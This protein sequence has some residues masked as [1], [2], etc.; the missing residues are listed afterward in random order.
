MKTK[1]KQKQQRKTKQQKQQQRISA[2][3]LVAAFCASLI[4]CGKSDVSVSGSAA[5]I[6][7]GVP[8]IAPITNNCPAGQISI[9]GAACAP[10]LATACY[11]AYGTLTTAQGVQVCRAQLTYNYGTGYGWV[12]YSWNGWREF[13]GFAILNPSAPAGN[14]AYDTGIIV[15]PNDRVEISAT[16]H[17]GYYSSSSFSWLGG[18]IQGVIWNTNC[19]DLDINGYKSGQQGSYEGLPTGL[20]MSDGGKVFFVG[21]GT[22]FTVVNPGSLKFGWNA[23]PAAGGGCGLIRISKLVVTRCQAAN[24]SLYVCP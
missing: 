24:G 14:S 22:T 5:P 18:L 15:G 19:D 17:W 10:D 16:G 9:A 13:G 3:I 6:T 7:P 21:G 20:V 12:N 4:G 1:Q 11:A 8:A 2:A 23:N